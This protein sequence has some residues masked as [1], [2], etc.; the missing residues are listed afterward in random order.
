MEFETPKSRVFI[1]TDN[2]SLIT[3]CEGEY[4]LPSNL[5]GWTL[6]E[7]GTPCDRL[8]LAQSHYFNGGLYTTDG[9]PRYKWNGSEAI[10]RTDEEINADRE[11]R[12]KPS[13]EDQIAS[14]KTQLSSTDYKI[15]KCS[16]AQLLGEELPYD[17]ASLHAERQALRDKIN[18]L[19]QQLEAN[20]EGVQSNASIKI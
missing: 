5:D 14:L 17:I 6:I 15:I 4:T 1:K 10:L 8:N 7:E 18:E 11:I 3:R 9:I 13:T 20:E 19:E 12:N 2:Q 16:E